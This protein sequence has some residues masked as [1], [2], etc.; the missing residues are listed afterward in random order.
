[1]FCAAGVLSATPLTYTM[2]RDHNDV[3]VFCLQSRKTR[4]RLRRASV[5]TG[6]RRAAGDDPENKRATRPR[7]SRR[8]HEER[9]LIQQDRS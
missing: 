8:A 6:C 3:V 1:M 4:R 7:Y 5:G 2:R 9:Q